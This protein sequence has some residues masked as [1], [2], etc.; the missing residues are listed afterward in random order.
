MTT[1]DQQ[2]ATAEGRA[3]E[4]QLAFVDHA[5]DPIERRRIAV[6]LQTIRARLT[7]L[8]LLQATQAA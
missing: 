6:Q 5:D 7:E 1:I 3:T 8:Y 2:I 4:L